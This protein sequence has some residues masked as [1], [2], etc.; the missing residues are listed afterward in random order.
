MY[1]AWHTKRWCDWSSSENEKKEMDPILMKN[2]KSVP[3][4]YTIWEN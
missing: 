1:V 2:C 3:W 4:Q